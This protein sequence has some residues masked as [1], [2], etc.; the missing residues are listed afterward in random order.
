M[1]GKRY[2]AHRIIYLMHNKRLPPC[3]DH[4]D[5]ECSNNRI[6][7]LREST[8]SENQCNRSKNKNNKSGYKGVHW[9]KKSKK[10][11]AKI[12]FNKKTFYLGLFDNPKEGA[13]AY[14]KKA[15]ELHGEFANINKFEKEV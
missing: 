5:R 8:M 14:N 3:I 7:N 2:K 10:W 12:A 13:E 4:I 6:E 11:V 9:N 1:S 15:I